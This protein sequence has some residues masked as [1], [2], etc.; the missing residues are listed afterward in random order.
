MSKVKVLFFTADPLSVDGQ[1]PRLLL[2]D[3]VRKIRI[4]VH[5]ATYRNKLSFNNHW[6][7][8]T[9]DLLHALNSTHPQVVHFSGHGGPDGLVLVSSDGQRPHAVGVNALAELL[10]EFAKDV[11]V[12]VLNACFSFAQ[13]QAIANVVGCAIGTNNE[14]SDQAAI[15]FSVSFYSA[16]AFGASV[17]A[18]YNQARSAL[19]L[20]HF[21]DRECP[22]LVVGL[23][24]DPTKLILIPSDSAEEIG[25]EIVA[26][27][28]LASLPVHDAVSSG[29]AREVSALPASGRRRLVPSRVLAAFTALVLS[30]AFTFVKPLEPSTAPEPTM[31]D[32]ACGTASSPRSGM[33]SSRTPMPLASDP[34]PSG[35]AQATTD[36]AQAKAFYRARKFEDAAP[37]FERAA[38]DGDSEAMG[39]IGYMY[40][41][42]KG[43]DAQPEVGIQWLRKAA[44]EERDA[45]GMYALAVAYLNGDGVARSEYH[46]REWFL[47]AVRENGHAESMRS[48]GS[49]AEPEKNDS[50]YR[51]ALEWYLGAVKA[52]SVD[53]RADIGLMYELGLGVARDTAAALQWYRFAAQAESMRGMVAMGRVHQN[54][55]GVRLDYRAAMD[56]YLRAAEAGSADA[57]N[58][59]GVLYAEGLGVRRNRG[60]A[61]RWF[62]RAVDAGS[63]AAGVNLKALGRG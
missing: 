43:V 45:H 44:S 10:E 54:G 49:L 15:T 2:D 53:A 13:A 28:P 9:Y 41:Y 14:I 37:A 29:D 57:M 38:R 48:L 19:K 1:R 24:V 21:H 12:V 40:L 55:V 7:T 33:R 3:E 50:S 59:I 61:I 42:G 6:A 31:S 17:Q 23:G 62:K 34:T 51:A 47:K 56:W 36:L 11:R 18:A 4:A 25:S 27:L 32:R 22:A 52:G 26:P 39:C 5:A 46:A 20:E 35:P 8:R 58:S 60:K 16:I 30:A 63:E